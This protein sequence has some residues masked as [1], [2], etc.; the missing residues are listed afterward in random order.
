MLE[1]TDDSAQ[2]TEDPLSKWNRIALEFS[3]DM[4]S[5]EDKTRRLALLKAYRRFVASENHSLP[6]P[7]SED[8]EIRDISDPRF[9]Q[10]ADQIV[11]HLSQKMLA[12][13]E[14]GNSIQARPYA[15]L[16]AK[17]YLTVLQQFDSV[18]AALMGWLASEYEKAGDFQQAQLASVY[19]SQIFDNLNECNDKDCRLQLNNLDRLARLLEKTGKYLEAEAIHID[20]FKLR[21]RAYGLWSEEAARGYRNLASYYEDTRQW[22]KAEEAYSCAHAIF[23]DV[24]G[25]NHLEVAKTL[26]DSA[27]L[28][29]SRYDWER[30]EANYKLAL[31]ALEEYLTT[32]AIQIAAVRCLLAHVYI[33]MEKVEQAQELFREALPVLQATHGPHD[34]LVVHTLCTLSDGLIDKGDLTSAESCLQKAIDIH[35]N[36]QEPNQLNLGKLS[37]KI[38]HAFERIDQSTTALMWYERALTG[39]YNHSQSIMPAIATEQDKGFCVQ[40]MFPLLG[41]FLS[42][43][44]NT[45]CQDH[46]TVRKGYTWVL[47]C[48][49]MVL[50]E[51]AK[52]NE[53]IRRELPAEGKEK[54]SV[55]QSLLQQFASLMLSGPDKLGLTDEAFEEKTSRLTQNIEDITKELIGLSHTPFHHR[56]NT[57]LEVDDFLQHLPPK[58]CIVEY[59]NVYDPRLGAICQQSETSHGNADRLLRT[60]AFVITSQH[61]ITLVDLGPTVELDEASLLARQAIQAELNSFTNKDA[62][63]DSRLSSDAT[64]SLKRLYEKIWEPFNSVLQSEDRV[65]I[66]PDGQLNLI[67]FGALVDAHNCY[68]IENYS[69]AYLLSG[70]ELVA[71]RTKATESKVEILAIANPQFHETEKPSHRFKPLPNTQKEVEAILPL[72]QGEREKIALYG[73]DAT[74]RALLTA[75]TPRI[76]HLATHGYFIQM[77][78]VGW[79]TTEKALMTAQNAKVYHLVKHGF[80]DGPACSAA[81]S[82]TLSLMTS[83]LVFAKSSTHPGESDAFLTALE[84]SGMD[85]DGCELVVL[86]ACHTG[87]GEPSSV[88]EGI[89][90]LRRAFSLA[91]AKNL[92]TSL[93]TVSEEDTPDQ[94]E[95]FYRYLIQ[96]SPADALREAQLNSIRKFRNEMEYSPVGLWAPFIVQGASAFE[97]QGT[98]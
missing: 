80:F 35:E 20:A 49:G 33:G 28:Y 69:V 87:M 92:L 11:I 58:T 59:V 10:F 76:L 27:A 43:I 18:V 32:D 65:F 45:F 34:A 75:K 83:G 40:K 53:L 29:S 52:L 97:E 14:M 91:G 54:L 13:I 98:S 70:K 68:L 79:T 44:A 55:R 23:K 42:L 8:S 95:D 57:N 6:I 72:I 26:S 15:E 71:Q 51:Q 93:W 77:A 25:E 50:D 5:S 16:L 94:I 73:K 17:C 12:Y 4:E 36:L 66:C 48:K 64:D 24:L 90:G 30:A 1:P 88:G 89:F 84:V 41:E 31:K 22:Q 56:Q 37:R 67:P 60:L 78:L 3:E 7:A 74:K 62:E 82:A 2:A 96:H 61:H 19:A 9:I 38:A 86:S 21:D 46:D 81:T 85:L 39:F 47:R 63:F